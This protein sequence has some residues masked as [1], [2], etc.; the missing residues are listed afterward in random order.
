M[1]P[2]R[3]QKDP[4]LVGHLKS[5]PTSEYGFVGAILLFNLPIVD[6]LLRL[7]SLIVWA[8]IIVITVQY[9]WLTMY[10]GRMEKREQFEMTV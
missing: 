7:H 6:N 1:L 5:A 9:E 4:A 8:L 3:F 10:L 2:R